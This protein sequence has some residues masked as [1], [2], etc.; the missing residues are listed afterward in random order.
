MSLAM[1]LKWSRS[2]GNAGEKQGVIAVADLDKTVFI[3]LGNIGEK[4]ELI[5]RSDLVGVLVM[6]TRKSSEDRLK[7]L[8]AELG[9]YSYNPL[10]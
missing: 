8:F 4:G 6:L 2:S 7:I 1:S 5:A 9:D 3:M 10:D